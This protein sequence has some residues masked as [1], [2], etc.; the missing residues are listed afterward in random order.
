M[1]LFTSLL[2]IGCLCMFFYHAMNI[3][4]NEYNKAVP[5]LKLAEATKGMIESLAKA[6]WGSLPLWRW[7]AL[8]LLFGMGAVQATHP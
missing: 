7:L 5:S 6:L 4:W 2:S 8:A 1:T 3:A